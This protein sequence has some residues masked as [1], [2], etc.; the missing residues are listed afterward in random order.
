MMPSGER[1]V[2]ENFESYSDGLALRESGASHNEETTGA[3]GDKIRRNATSRIDGDTSSEE[4]SGCEF[5]R[6][7][8]ISEGDEEYDC[9]EE[10]LEKVF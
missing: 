6:T 5:G 4:A 10:L 2:G 7:I 8:V 3:E 1:D 9:L